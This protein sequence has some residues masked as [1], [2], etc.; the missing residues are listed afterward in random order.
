LLFN[1]E[2]RF[3]AFCLTLSIVVRLCDTD[4]HTCYT[5]FVDCVYEDECGY[6]GKETSVRNLA[7]WLQ[8]NCVATI[9]ELRARPCSTATAPVTCPVVEPC[10]EVTACE[11]PTREGVPTSVVEWGTTTC[12]DVT[13]PDAE[14][15]EHTAE[16]CVIHTSRCQA[17]LEAASKDVA[18]LRSG[19]KTCNRS[20]EDVEKKISKVTDLERKVSTC[21][22]GYKECNSSIAAQSFRELLVNFTWS[23]ETEHLRFDLGDCVKDLEKKIEAFKKKEEEMDAIKTRVVTVEGSV[24]GL[25]T[26]NR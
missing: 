4:C 17:L 15:P 2:K 8:K 23:N 24:F 22:K 20:L 5:Q 1:F 6:S 14:C 26:D 3:I 11:C 13:C 7:S 9:R 18:K 19:Y 12:P 25:E 21:E 10:G 16:N